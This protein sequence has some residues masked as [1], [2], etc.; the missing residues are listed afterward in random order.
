MQ[1]LL[2][3]LIWKQHRHDTVGRQSTKQNKYPSL[4]PLF[5][6]LTPSPPS[7]QKHTLTLNLTDLMG[8]SWETKDPIF[9]LS[10]LWFFLSDVCVFLWGAEEKMWRKSWDSS[11]SEP[12]RCPYHPR[13][14]TPISKGRFGQ[15]TT[16]DGAARH[17]RLK[18]CRL[19]VYVS[20]PRWA[21]FWEWM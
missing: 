9:H 4:T 12:K 19:A 14:V 17:R 16:L 6:F 2:S 18:E 13:S 10:Y 7:E 1:L 8:Y 21:D 11:K 15:V 20:W 3:A 5:P